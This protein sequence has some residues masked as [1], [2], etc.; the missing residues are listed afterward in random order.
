MYGNM[1]I[2]A[3][4]QQS[5]VSRR[6]NSHCLSRRP[7]NFDLDE[8]QIHI[9]YRALLNP[10]KIQKIPMR[11]GPHAGS[12]VNRVEHLMTRSAVCHATCME[13][14]FLSH[15]VHSFRIAQKS[16]TLR[17]R[18]IELLKILGETG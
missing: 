17:W 10:G 6:L 15:G 14:S 2:L 7:T 9:R 18:N 1:L 13:P 3:R 11:P 12:K 16:C 8:L 5:Q 4:K